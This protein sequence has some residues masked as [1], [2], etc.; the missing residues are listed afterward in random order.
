[1]RRMLRLRAVAVLLGAL[2]VAACSGASAPVEVPAD[3]LPFSLSRSPTP[4]PG[5]GD[6]T[7]EITFVHGG[8]LQAVVRTAD[9]SVPAPEAAIRALLKGPTRSERAGGVTSSVPPATQLIG[10]VV[11]DQI[12][13]VDLSGEFQ[14]PAQPRE[15]LLR[16]AQVVWTLVGIPGVTAVRFAIDG[17]VVPVVT[18]TGS[19][20]ARPVSAPDYTAV[21]PS[22]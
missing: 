3:Q 17:E 11:T 4:S 10:I 22:T 8:R 12:A 14:T 21:A 2:L 9:A 15:V 1:M 13:E 16:V 6:Q 19:S 7:L 18:D 5:T 20:V